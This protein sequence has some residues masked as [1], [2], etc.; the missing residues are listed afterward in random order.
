MRHSGE[1]MPHLNSKANL[2]PEIPLY[3]SLAVPMT[4][5]L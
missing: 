2:L 1:L 5:L 3:T 4:S